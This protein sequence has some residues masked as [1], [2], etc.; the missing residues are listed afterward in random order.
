MCGI[1]GI[2][3]NSS[4]ESISAMVAAMHHRG[5]DD[6]GM[7]RDANIAMGMAR[8]A[9]IDITS[10][11]HQPMGNRNASIW[12][13]YN[14]EMYNFRQE[15]SILEGLGHRFDTHSDTEVVLCMYEVYGDDFL[16]RLRG[17]F[18]LAIYDKRKGKGKERL[19]LARDH[20]GI[21]PLIYCSAE[22]SAG[23]HFLFA[24]EIKALLAS[25]LVAPQIEPEALRLLLTFGSINQPY[26]I[27]K[28]VKMLL[29]GHRLVVENSVERIERFWRLGVGRRAGEISGLPYRE[30]VSI[31]RTN[32]EE[33]VR[34]Q[35]VSDVPLGAFLSGG[36]DS[37]L[38]VAMMARNSSQCIKTFSVG[39]ESE[40]SSMDESGDAEQI[41]RFIG[42]DHNRVVVTGEQ[43]R[44]HIHHIAAALDQPSVDG[45]NSYFVSLAARQAVTVAISGTGGDELF[46]GYPWFI[47]MVASAQRVLTDPLRS[48]F[49]A[50][51][52]SIARLP[53]FDAFACSGRLGLMIQALR[54]SHDFVSRYARIFQIFG[55][56][57]AARFLSPV[58]RSLTLTGH[59]QSLDVS[60]ADEIPMAQ[61]LER[62]SALCLRGYTQNQLLRD[63]DAVSMAHS[64]EVRVPFL[65]PLLTDLALSLPREAK[66]GSL[67]GVPNP[68]TASYHDT[69]TKKVLV[70]AGEGLLLPG[71]DRQPKRGFSMPFDSW[72]KGPLRDVL[73]DAL[74]PATV[75]RRGFFDEAEVSQLKKDFLEGNGSWPQPWLLMMTE[76]WC[77]EV[78]DNSNRLQN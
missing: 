25:G 20:L 1:A 50:L 30:L 58:M 33:N 41:A 11:G 49:G 21:K 62:V 37:S 7:Y 39:F 55:V 18:A 4:P 66:L 75:K 27:I 16:L 22:C 69:G 56:C 32:L 52:A 42:T 53:S 78:L 61:P 74:S 23:T 72:L 70:D 43:V 57:G 15:K 47:T 51:A 10:A 12:I 13:V 6:S 3:G 2:T 45:V 65:D 77:R 68:E 67:A 63:I 5:P 9:V 24:S 73:D 34:M 17:M 31:V 36:V 29:P 59:E 60:Q 8:L 19:L 48:R 40:G 35:M 44:E 71:I 28:G 14:G 38:L 54:G 26:T 64:L 76:L 46:A